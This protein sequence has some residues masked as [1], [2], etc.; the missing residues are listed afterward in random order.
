MEF[1]T[2]QQQLNNALQNRHKEN[3][4]P[5]LPNFLNERDKRFIKKIRANNREEGERIMV[6]E[7]IFRG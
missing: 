5:H 7:F 2:D 3:K 4:L 1:Q 6:F